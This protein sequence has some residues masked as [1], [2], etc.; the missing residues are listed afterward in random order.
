MVLSLFVAVFGIS[1]VPLKILS[2]ASIVGAMALFFEA[3]KN[4]IP[5][6]ILIISTIVLSI[7]AY[8]LYYASQTYNEAFYLLVQMV[9]VW[10]FFK[11]FPGQSDALSVKQ[12]LKR[13]FALALSLL[14][15][16]L[17]KNAGFAALFAVAGYFLLQREWKNLLYSLLAFAV[18]LL[19]FQGIKYALWHED[20]LQFSSQGSSLS[21]KD[22]Y[23]PQ[24]GKEDIAGYF[25][26]LTG[27]SNLY[28][29]KH[30]PASLGL[31][32]P[33]PMISTSSIVTILI[34]LLAVISLV[35]T[36]RKNKYLFFSTLMAGS[37]L[38]VSFVIL[39][40]K[41][42]QSRLVIPAIPF[43]LIG[44]LSAL[45]Y[46][47]KLNKL[48]NLQWLLPIVGLIL[49]LQGFAA[50]AS[51]IKSN[52]Q[53]RG[54]YGGLTPDWKNYLKASEWAAEN[55]SKDAVIACRK[56]SISFV[57]GKGRNFY[58]IMQLP[59]YNADV[60]LKNWS[61]SPQNF[62]VFN[63]S[64]FNGRSISPELFKTLKTNMLALLFV[65]DS[66]YFA[67][68]V[69][70]SSVTNLKTLLAQSGL[71]N[72]PNPEYIR[73]S[74]TKE[75]VVKIYYPDSLIQQLQNQH[76]THVLTANLRRNITRKDGMII[77]T[78]ERYIAFIQEKY[79]EIYTKVVQ[80]GDDGN[81]PATIIKIDYAK[82]GFNDKLL[83]SK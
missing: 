47:T 59:N 52:Q 22:Y 67:D 61:E 6:T 37:F 54:M 51:A 29:S 66:L 17:T 58:G 40:V 30:F 39:Q 5:S 19:V 57:Y 53:I 18:V 14:A 71:Q 33:D 64:D 3:F 7:N 49:I 26:R 27:N 62:F 11:K 25:K 68:K 48:K 12:D 80:I 72:V 77:N 83:K 74:A 15:L 32:N 10:V 44:L 82:Y 70:D 65:G 31:R 45:Y 1:L 79:P 34:Y 2:M 42:D 56:P 60:F 63:Y 76:V 69:P 21:N 55:L 36:Y 50:S 16:V 9:V 20:G 75:S 13:H 38:L 73:K 24:A 23:N 4:R 8:I 43:L 28:L 46:A 78:V 35:L 41:W 81:E